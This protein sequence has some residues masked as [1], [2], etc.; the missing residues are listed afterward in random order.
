MTSIVSIVVDGVVVDRVRAVPDADA[1]KLAVGLWGP[2]A[3]AVVDAPGAEIGSSWRGGR[4][5]DPAPEAP[6]PEPVDLLKLEP[7]ALLELVTDA[8]TRELLRRLVKP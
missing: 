8:P 6:L 7:A 5:F 1:Q 2:E 4:V 3:V